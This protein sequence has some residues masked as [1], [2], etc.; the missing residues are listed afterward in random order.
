MTER[1]ARGAIQRLALALLVALFAVGVI[2]A[3][4]IARGRDAMQAS[5]EAFARGDHRAAT[6]FAE[7]AAQARFPGSPY[8]ER[9]F[10]RLFAIADARR[11]ANDDEGEKGALRAVIVAAQTTGEPG[12]PHADEARRRLVAIRQR[13]KP[14]GGVPDAAPRTGDPTPPP[15]ATA[16]PKVGLGA[17]AIVAL[18]ALVWLVLRGGRAGFVVLIAAIAGVVLFALQ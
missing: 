17:S 6:T 1:P 16:T 18:G 15:R 5:D 7:R 12:S 3:A 8:P 9:G 13:P 14:G 11:E 2:A 4:L 10:A